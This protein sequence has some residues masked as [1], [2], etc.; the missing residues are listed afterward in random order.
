MAPICGGGEIL[1]FLGDGFLA[2]YPCGRHKEPS[3]VACRAALTAM[4]K[5]TRRMNELNAERKIAGLAPIGYGI[6]LHVGD[7]MFGNVGLKDRL[8][9]SA[10]GAAV[11][12]VQRLQELTKKYHHQVIGS[13]AFADYAGGAWTTLGDEKLRGA[14]ETITVLAPDVSAVSPVT[15]EEPVFEPAQPGLSDAENVILLH[16]DQRNPSREAELKKALQ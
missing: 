14:D 12:E 11:N 3:K 9:F 7:V 8:T 1:S 16:R 10:F 2:V 15:E 6:G 4:T 13:S 5:A